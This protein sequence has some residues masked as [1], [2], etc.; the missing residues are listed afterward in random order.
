MTNKNELNFEMLSSLL[1]KDGKLNLVQD[2]TF[3]S[4]SAGT[5][6][7]LE[8]TYGLV[9][10]DNKRELVYSPFGGEKGILIGTRPYNINNFKKKNN[11]YLSFGGP[12]GGPSPSE[13][14]LSS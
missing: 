9:T 12:S 4:L 11:P 10:T 3:R 1:H 7:V 14:S 2:K 13:G 8:Q 6:K 5:I